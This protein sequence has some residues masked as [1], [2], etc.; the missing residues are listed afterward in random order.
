MANVF[1]NYGLNYLELDISQLVRSQEAS[2]FYDNINITINGKPYE[3]VAEFV[4]YSNGYVSA[5]FGGYGFAVNSTGQVVSGTVTGFIE[6]Y[7]NGAQYVTGWGIENMSYPA[8]SLVNT[9]YT[10]STIDDLAAISQIL[11]GND[12]FSL[13]NYV[14]IVRGFQ[15]NDALLGYGGNDFLFGDEGNDYLDGGIA[16]DYLDGG[17]GYD[18]LYGGEGDDELLGAL[19]G[20]LIYGEGGNDL[21]RGGNGLDRLDGGFGNDILLGALGTD[22]LTGGLGSDTFRFSTALDGQINIDTITDFE[23]GIDT[24]ELSAS[25]F[26]AFGSQIGQTVGLSEYLQY[27]SNSGKLFYDADGVGSGAGVQFA[28]LGTSFHPALGSDFLIV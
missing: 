19:N 22:T 13:S 1:S 2:Y 21:L 8:V 18:V 11:S 6:S 23:S 24:I 12:N 25:V 5:D 26:K 7:W 3:D 17:I 14:D 20:D 4:Y 10:T 16:N 28:V 9:A 27:E 15:G